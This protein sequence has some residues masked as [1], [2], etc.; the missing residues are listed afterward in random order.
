MKKI[1]IVEDNKELADNFSLLLQDKG[2][3]VSC[4]YNGSSGLT[5]MLEEKPELILCDIMLP[6]INGYKL[7]NE[8]KKIN[9]SDLP[10]FIFITAKNQRPDFRKAMNLGA[11][12]YI[13][14]PFTM[15]ELLQAIEAQFAKRKNLIRTVEAESEN[16]SEGE[17]DEKMLNYGDYIF[18]QDKKNPGFYPVS[19]IVII[20][21]MKDYT[22]VN[23][24]EEKKFIVRKPMV[25]WEKRLPSEKFYRIHK[26]TIINIEFI[27]SIENLSSGRYRVIMKN[28]GENLEVSQRFGKKIRAI[29]R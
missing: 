20:K 17:T 22:R 3:T 7:L 9:K 21:S 11:D 5:K 23:L 1:L 29:F 15:S 4:A 6:D 10:V 2:Y 8:L 14:K 19:I 25:Y 13:T 12:D 28:S 24:T 26:Q 27:E 18:F 16:K